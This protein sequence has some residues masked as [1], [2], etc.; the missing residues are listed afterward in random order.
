MFK[1][2]NIII[3][4]LVIF[5]F[6]ACPD[7]SQPT[8]DPTPGPSPDGRTY[9][10]IENTTQYAVNVYINDPPLYNTPT[11]TLRMVPAKSSGQWELQPTEE[12]KNGETLYFEYLIPIGSTTV[13]YYPRNTE[14]IKLKKLEAGKVN[15]QEV[16]ALGSAQTD[17][18]FVLIKNNSND[19]IWFEQ[20]LSDGVSST[21][22]PFG[23][24]NRD[25]P[26]RRD[27]VFVFGSD[28]ASLRN[29]T[30][31]NTTRLNFPNIQLSKG[32]VYTFIYDG[33]NNPSLF[34]MESF[35]PDMAKN[36]WSMPTSYKI[37]QFLQIGKQRVRRNPSDGIVVLGRL[38]YNYGVGINSRAYFALVN[39]YGEVTTERIFNLPNDPIISF[40]EVHERATGDFIISYVASYETENKLFLM[41]YTQNGVTKWQ[42]ELNE[43][44]FSSFDPDSWY[45][46]GTYIAEKD[47]KTFAIGGV[48]QERR[49]DGWHY[50]AFVTEVKENTLGTDASVSWANP[51]ISDFTLFKD[52]GVVILSI[53][54][55]QGLV[56]NAAQDAYIVIEL[57]AENKKEEGIY[58][59][60]KAADGSIIG[61][62][63]LGEFT[64]FGFMG[65]HQDGDRYYVYGEYLDINEKYSAVALGFKSDMT[66]DPNFSTVFIPSDTGYSEFDA[67]DSDSFKIVFAG[68]IY[69]GNRW[70]PWTYAVEKTTGSKLWE[71]VYDDVDYNVI[72]NMDINSIG[73]LQLEFW[74]S[75]YTGSSLL[76]ST[77]FFGKISGERKAPIPR[78]SSMTVNTPA[79]LEISVSITPLSDAGLSHETLTLN[80]GQSGT[81]SVQGTWSSYQWYI[82]GEPVSGSSG[83]RSGLSFTTSDRNA[84]VYTVTAVVTDSANEKRSASCRITVIN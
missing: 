68:K 38:D 48:I 20:G 79:E 5:I 40:L 84:G 33:I 1:K 18:A 31:G 80:K 83:S 76:V 27:A 74:D 35:D 63:L 46:E 78:N 47:N 23:S 72:W 81:I 53:R 32:Y 75:D 9:L 28:V 52:D 13:P 21:K 44:V 6:L 10:K 14:N 49:Q 43:K 59:I 51:Y 37:G 29:C 55:C 58:R 34:L 15:T 61:Q 77:D 73:T 11:G 4:L 22:Y 7:N 82:N 45:I 66:L 41:C 17:S 69:N 50:A 25:I 56:Y 39:Q 2:R 19:T 24:S 67:C 64:R 36:I 65:I 71:N 8:S 42:I 62:N 26:A 16:P 70:I 30:I 57:F 12:G 3:G 54:Q 60:L